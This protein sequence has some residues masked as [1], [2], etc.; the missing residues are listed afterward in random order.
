MQFNGLNSTS[1]S[2]IVL[3]VEYCDA[4]QEQQQT[5]EFVVLLALQAADK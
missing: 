5:E 1:E 3:L 4:N 2:R